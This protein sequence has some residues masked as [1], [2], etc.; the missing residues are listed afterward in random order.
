[1]EDIDEIL[2]H[3]IGTETGEKIWVSTQSKSEVRSVEKGSFRSC[4]KK[5]I[6]N[7][8]MGRTQESFQPEATDQSVAL[9]AGNHF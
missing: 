6:Q 5:C 1:M 8:A 2:N 4:G 7:L 9:S 3:L